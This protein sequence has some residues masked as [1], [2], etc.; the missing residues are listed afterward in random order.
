MIQYNHSKINSIDRRIGEALLLS[1]I[2]EW[3]AEAR[4]LLAIVGKEQRRELENIIAEFVDI[5][6]GLLQGRCERG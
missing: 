1:N 2:E 3:I 5:Q 4:N 6:R